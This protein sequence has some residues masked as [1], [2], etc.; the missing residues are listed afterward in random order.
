MEKICID[1]IYFYGKKEQFLEFINSNM[2]AKNVTLKEFLYLK[3]KKANCQKDY[4]HN[5][6]QIRRP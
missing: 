6:Q 1:G 3:L 2:W 5:M 4:L